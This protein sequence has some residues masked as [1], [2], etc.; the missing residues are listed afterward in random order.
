[1]QNFSFDIIGTHLGLSL[2]TETDC[3]LLF[4]HIQDRLLWF[5]KKFSRF[6]EWNWLYTLNK[7]REATLDLDGKNM[8]SFA[9]RIADSTDGYFDPTVG[10]RL[11]ELWYGNQNILSSHTEKY[12]GNYKDVEIRDE[13]VF[14]WRDVELEF[15]W[16][17]KGYLIDVLYAM[18]CSYE[19]NISRFIINFGWDMY[20]KWGWKVWLESPF[21]SDEVIGIYDLQDDFFACSAGTKRKWW[22]HHHLIDPH[23]GESAREVIASYIEGWSGILTDTYATTLCVMPWDTACITLEKTAEISGVIVKHDGTLYQ[24]S[25]SKIQLF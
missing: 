19:K 22:N 18:I 25:G 15:W 21:A 10:R 3:S 4:A 23:T 5:E 2:E 9:L 8:L 16:V 1:M 12:S 17:G 24:K 13:R 7:E 11:T 6:I 20:G 14:L